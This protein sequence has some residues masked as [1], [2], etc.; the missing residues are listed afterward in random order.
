MWN[1]YQSPAVFTSV[2]ITGAMASTQAPKAGYPF[3]FSCIYT[4]L[5]YFKCCCWMVAQVNAPKIFS[6]LAKQIHSIQLWPRNFLFSSFSEFW[7]NKEEWLQMFCKDKNEHH[8][9]VP[10]CNSEITCRST[11][12]LLL[13]GAHIVKHVCVF[14]VV[15]NRVT[16]GSRKGRRMNSWEMIRTHLLLWKPSV[17]ATSTYIL[18]RFLSNYAHGEIKVVGF[19]QTWSMPV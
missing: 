15:L 2:L 9:S 5:V 14:V 13:L 6:S 12:S 11:W 1:N 17:I 18:G 16:I 4:T 7:I 10:A 3:T 19:L 8:L